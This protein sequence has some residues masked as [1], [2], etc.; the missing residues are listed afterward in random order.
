MQLALFDFDGTLTS[1]DMYSRFLS[2]RLSWHRQI[3]GRCALAPFYLAYKA[4]WLSGPQLRLWA[5]FFTTVGRMRREVS[6]AGQTFANHEIPQY[7]LA[8]A[9]DRLRWHQAQGHQVVIVSASMDAYL[10]PWCQAQGVDLL[11]SELAG[12]TRLTGRYRAGDCTNAA[13]AE[14]VRAHYD[15]ASYQRIYAYGN[16]DEDLDMLALADEG[17]MNAELISR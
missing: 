16:T 17:Y 5:T 9:M 2:Y 1:K 15:L 7:Y 12:K 6:E 13:K 14:K 8:W 10:Q 3:W 11:C 4:G